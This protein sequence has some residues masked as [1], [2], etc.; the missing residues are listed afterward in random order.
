[1]LWFHWKNEWPLNSPVQNPLDYNVWGAI[2]GRCQKFTPKPSNIAELKTAFLF[3]WNDLPQEFTDKAILSFQNRCDFRVLLQ[4]VD[5]WNTTVSLNTEK[6]A[7]I[8]HWNVWTVDEK[9]VQCFIRHYWI[10]TTLVHVK[11]TLKFKRL[12]LLNHM[13]YFNIICSMCGLNPRL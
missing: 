3:I 4:L 7:D 6:A 9:I 13:S 5:I 12:Y 10:F 11:W 1:M 2:L 8:H